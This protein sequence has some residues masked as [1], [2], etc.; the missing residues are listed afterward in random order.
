MVVGVSEGFKKEL[1]I[2]G[3]GYR[4]AV[5]GNT[6]TLNV[7]FSHP[8]NFEVENGLTVECPKPDQIVVSGI[9][10]Q[11]VGEFAANIRATRKPEP[12]KGKGI[13]YKGEHILRKE[14]KKAA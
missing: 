9:D 1:Q 8:V 2:T 3:I 13:A 6:L 14:G 10:K 4:A 11:R 5:S 7:G 12:Y